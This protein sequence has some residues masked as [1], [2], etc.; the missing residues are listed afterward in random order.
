M[1]LLW[2]DKVAWFVYKIYKS[3]FGLFQALTRDLLLP[4]TN[5]NFK[6]LPAGEFYFPNITVYRNERMRSYRPTTNDRKR[7]TEILIKIFF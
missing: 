2:H 5:L 6:E 3:N 1:K 4:G 7:T